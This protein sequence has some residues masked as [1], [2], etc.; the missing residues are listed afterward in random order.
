MEIDRFPVERL[1]G[2]GRYFGPEASAEVLEVSGRC[3]GSSRRAGVL[4][5]AAG[6]PQIEQARADGY[7]AIVL[8]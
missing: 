5:A 7:R 2:G 3:Q 1:L 8:R 6:L 4:G